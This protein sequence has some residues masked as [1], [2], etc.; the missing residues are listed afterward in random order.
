MGL[1]LN[2][3]KKFKSLRKVLEAVRGEV[4]RSVSIAIIAQPEAEE[5]LLASMQAGDRHDV[6]FGV[7]VKAKDDLAAKLKQADLALV[8]ISPGATEAELKDMFRQA[9]LAKRKLAIVTGR[10]I[11]D[12]MVDKLASVYH[13]SGEDVIF[14]PVSDKEA[15]RSKLIPRIVKKIE[16]KEIALAAAVPA[17]KQEVAGRVIAKT[18]GQ[19]AVIGAAIFIPGADMPIMTANQIKMILRLSAVYNEEISAKRLYEILAVIGGGFAF[20]EIAKQ[21]LGLIPV[22]GWAIKGGIGYGGTVAMGQVAKKY[23]EN[24]DHRAREAATD[25]QE[26]ANAKF[27]EKN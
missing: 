23:F 7:N 14:V 6:F 16:D 9:S 24:S 27:K 26:Y 5:D 20:R 25:N 19:N 1:T 2:Y 17:F 3:Y 22:A 4:E 21:A 12:W 18:A 11:S 10:E 13:V 8:V 15:V